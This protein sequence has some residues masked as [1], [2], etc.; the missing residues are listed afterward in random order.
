MT[1]SALT[2]V[3]LAGILPGLSGFGVAAAAVPRIQKI[4][5]S[6]AAP[7]G[8]VA[9][10]CV[11]PVL[12]YGKGALIEKVKVFDVFY[13]PGNPYE[14]E[15]GKYYQAITNSSLFDMLQEYNVKAGTM[16][17]TQDWT[18]SRGSY[19]GK[20]TDTNKATGPT[21]NLPDQQIQ[22]YLDGL[23]TANK[24]PA[25]DDNMFYVI[26]F[27]GNVNPTTPN[28][29]SC[30]V[31]GAAFCAYHTSFTST[32]GANVRYAVMPNQD[33]GDCTKVCG[34]TGLAGWTAVASH[35]LIESVTDPDPVSGWND[36]ADPTH[37]GEIGDICTTGL[38]DE[39]DLVN[40]YSVQKE[41][42]NALKSCA[43]ANPMYDRAVFSI[44]ASAV[45]IP[46]GGSATTTL[47]FTN[48]SGKADTIT[49]APTN[50]PTGLSATFNP[51]SAT[52]DHGTI[53]ATISASGQAAL[54]TAKLTMTGTGAKG[55][56][57]TVDVSVNV[58]APP[59]YGGAGQSGPRSRRWWRR[60]WIE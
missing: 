22:T 44:A 26:Y 43:V 60:R 58:V 8:S 53:V 55:E 19:V 9:P 39:S 45:S 6:G 20:F 37:C 42:S 27:P 14:E 5:A 40:G 46:L 35:E 25:P 24:V 29:N 33:T 21:I 54:G 10:N 23:I 13:A 11:N 18:I 51:A 48:T 4:R 16:G 47:S 41:W 52:S 17:A 1:R 31:K 57:A 34:A 12:T 32:S 38:M 2:F 50:P 49:V 56:T 59:E 36:N 30:I 28:G 7:N 15:F 3:L